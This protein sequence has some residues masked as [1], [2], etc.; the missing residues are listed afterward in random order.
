MRGVGTASRRVRAVALTGIVLAVIVIGSLTALASKVDPIYVA[1]NPTCP[2]GLTA[3]DIDGS[4]FHNGTQ[5]D[6]TL[7]V[8][9]SNFD[10]QTTNF[11]W[12]SNIGVD[13]VIVKGGPN[14]NV[15]Q[16]DPDATSDTGLHTPFN[17]N[18]GQN[19]GLSH[20]LF[21]Y[22]SEATPTP[23]PTSSVSPT[24]TPTETVSPTPTPTETVSPTPTPTT[25]ETPTVSPTSTTTGGAGGASPSP[26]VSV[27][28][29]KLGRT[30]ADVLRLALL[31]VMLVGFGALSYVI[32]RRSAK[33]R[34]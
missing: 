23:T 19:Y 14:A 33:R 32:V 34:A 21:C 28:G 18:S 1:G 5:S 15:Y 10:P 25:T 24:P 9:I 7:T 29:E 26:S 20:V 12:S 22:D 16:Y 30:G 11:D 6:G 8:T 13:E 2:E 17:Q 27:L 31:A 3:L 4:G